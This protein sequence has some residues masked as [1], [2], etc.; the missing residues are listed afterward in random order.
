MSRPL[1]LDE[2]MPD[3]LAEKVP[4]TQSLRWV[5]D[6]FTF[7]RATR[8]QVALPG[9]R[10]YIG[11]T[12]TRKKLFFF[13]AC[14]VS[15]FAAIVGRLAYI[16]LILGNEYYVMAEGNRQRIV[17]IPAE[18]GSIFDSKRRPF[19]KNIP[20]FSLAITPQHLPRREE[21]RG[22]LVLRLA[23]ITGRDAKDLWQILEDYGAYG[24]ESIIIQEHLDYE[25]ALSI[26]I[27]AADFPGIH[28]VRGSKREYLHD[29]PT[30]ALYLLATT[31]QSLAHVIG[32]EGK[33]S[34]EELD[35]L[36][37]E[38]YLPSDLIG[39]TGVEKTYESYLRGT[40]GKKRIEVDALGREQSILAEIAPIPGY[41]ISLSID[42]AVQGTLEALLQQTLRRNGK[43]R[44][45]AVAMDPNT[46]EVLA[47]V[48]LPAYDNNLFSSGISS[49]AFAALRDQT[50]RPLFAR[51]IGGMYPSGSTI[52]PAIAAAALAEGIIAPASVFLSTGG[53]RVGEWFFPDW[54]P[55]GHGWTDVISSIANSVNTFYYYI[56]GGYEKVQGLGVGRI[57]DYL[58]R[59]GFGN[60]LGIDAQGESSGFLPSESWKREAKGE[61]WYIG[62]TY[63][64]SIGQGD[65]LVTPLQIAAMTAVVANGGTLY[66]PHVVR[67]LTNQL[68]QTETPVQPTVIRE[69]VIPDA[70]LAIVRQGMRACVTRGSCRLLNDLPITVA[71]KTG[72]AE[73][74]EDRETHGWFTSFAPAENPKIVLTILVEEGGEGSGIAAPIAR[75]FYLWWVQYAR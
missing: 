24:Y 10:A 71:G 6:S 53:L 56:G 43:R 42:A 40:Y 58:S 63:N 69:S 16:Q 4:R 67:G 47:L 27:A 18:R 50:D 66:R 23:D 17:P 70:H 11:S 44:A 52:K 62:D 1:F 73:W 54:K 5:E 36:Y 3:D 46:G 49:E 32:Y 48:S 74:R 7:E 9:N 31:T 29:M 34:R 26:Q 13:L 35:A 30:E 37:A 22:A 39:K 8:R 14:V 38:G 12:L 60:E 28:I 41:D 20:N 25:T 61:A 72:T 45:A 59:F 64:L 19:T 57:T 21:E 15:V 2:S 33:L 75:Y 65:L 55:A 51:A 68:D